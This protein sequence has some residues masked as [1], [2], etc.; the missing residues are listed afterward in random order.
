MNSLPTVL[1]VDDDA[2]TVTIL[3]HLLEAEFDVLFASNGSEALTLAKTARPDLVLLDV[4]MSEM[5]GYEV[6]KRLKV[7]PDTADIPVIF[8]TGLDDAQAE[9]Q[10]LEAGALDYVTKP[11]NAAIVRARVRNHVALKR[12]RDTLQMLAATDGLTALANRRRFDETLG[13][14]CRRSA[15]TQS[16]LGLIMLDIDHFKAYN[17]AYGHVAGDEC[18][19]K[20]AGTIAGALRRV[21]DLAARYGG[22]EFACILPE[23]GREGTLAVAMRI[24][25]DIRALAIIHETSPV[26]PTLTCSMGITSV[27]CS[28]STVPEDVVRLSDAALYEAKRRGRDRIEPAP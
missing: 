13:S 3:A 27:R 6:C 12:A 7:D 17:D 14:E 28:G 24:Q 20:V 26:Q 25:A 10:G 16:E 19:R 21:P 23:T 2:V 5:N 18:L 8:I 11:F 4:M 9:S 15:R 1:V 22:E